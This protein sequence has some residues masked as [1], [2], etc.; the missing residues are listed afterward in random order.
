MADRCL[1]VRLHS[2]GDV[3]LASGAARIMAESIETLFATDPLYAPVALRIPGNITVKTV[4]GWRELRRAAEGCTK[5]IDLQNNAA[6]RFALAGKKPERYTF[7]RVKRRR[8]LRGSDES[9]EYRPLG[10][11]KTSGL[12]GDP[13]PV[14]QRRRF[15]EPGAL[16]VG[17]VV[18]GRWPL[19]SI[20][21]GIA[22]EL[23]RLFC[24]VLHARVFLL[25]AGSD[26][27]AAE[28]VAEQ[29]GYRNAVSV[30]GEG[31]MEKLLER[32]E[33]LDLLVSPDSGPAHLGIA[34]G[35]PTQ[36]VFTSTSS[37]LGFFRDDFPGSFMVPDVPCRPCHRHGGRKC[38]A[39]DER[40][41]KMLVPREMFQEAL[42]LIR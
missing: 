8:I 32:I 14:L 36:V 6:T 24:D 1:M 37:A 13:A 15:P 12:T 10:Y 28:S 29:C 39:G 3:V 9:M 42:C 25:G 33:G 30:A 2:L 35:V 26:R 27:A 19:K 17:I 40:C 4:S 23:A 38:R 20:P 7:S 21:E 31:G 34:L 41:R 5:V 18:G 11:L 16:T 22:A